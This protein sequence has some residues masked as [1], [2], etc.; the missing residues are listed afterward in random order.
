MPPM[1]D[2]LF[3]MYVFHTCAR[4]DNIVF[5]AFSYPYCLGDLVSRVWDVSAQPLDLGARF[6]VV[7]SFGTTLKGNS[8]KQCTIKDE[9][10]PL[11][12]ILVL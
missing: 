6:G 1:R 12:K 4:L 8:Y 9:K 5:Y 2:V 10:V 11:C 3:L 7:W